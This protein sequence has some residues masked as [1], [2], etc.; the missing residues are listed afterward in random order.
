[1][2]VMRMNRKNCD[3]LLDAEIA[4]ADGAYLPRLVH[5]FHL[6]PRLF[7]S[8]RVIRLKLAG[9]GTAICILSWFVI[10]VDDGLGPVHEPLP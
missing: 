1:M 8:D 2:I 7:E 4:H 10:V 6:G 9:L 3:A 5:F